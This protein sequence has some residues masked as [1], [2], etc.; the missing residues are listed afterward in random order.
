MLDALLGAVDTVLN[1]T[2]QN[3]IQLSVQKDSHQINLIIHINKYKINVYTVKEK[4]HVYLGPIIGVPCLFG[5]LW[6][7]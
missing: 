2:D 3:L 1:K 5:A 7:D 4:C 6:E